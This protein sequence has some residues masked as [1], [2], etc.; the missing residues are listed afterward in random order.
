MVQTCRKFEIPGLCCQYKS[1]FWSM[2][3]VP[4][5]VIVQSTEKNPTFFWAGKES[6]HSSNN[7]F[8]EA[9]QFFLMPHKTFQAAIHSTFLLPLTLHDK[10]G[11]QLVCKC[12]A[13]VP[14]RAFA[15]KN[16]PQHYQKPHFMAIWK[17]LKRPDILFNGIMS[18]K[19]LT[20]AARVMMR[21]KPHPCEAGG[22]LEKSASFPPGPVYNQPA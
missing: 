13:E 6:M 1:C 20:L 14:W 18:S 22:T 9:K 16:C 19:K 7:I 5:V 8:M 11:V 10:Q 12:T 21:Q 15:K 3:K 17:H 2:N 4:S